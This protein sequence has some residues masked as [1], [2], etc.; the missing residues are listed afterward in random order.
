MARGKSGEVIAV[1]VPL[2]CRPHIVGKSELMGYLG[3][4]SLI[5]LNKNYLSQGL[6]WDML[7][8]TKEYYLKANVDKWLVEHS[9]E[10]QEV[11][12]MQGEVPHVSKKERRKTMLRSL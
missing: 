2:S 4:D 1:E 8:G 7:I 12:Y 10:W 5:T 9:Q 3:V 11:T 6:H